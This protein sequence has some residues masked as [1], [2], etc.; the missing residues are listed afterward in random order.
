[1]GYHNAQCLQQ[2]DLG[3]ISPIIDRVRNIL[4]SLTTYID[5]F[6][7]RYAQLIQC[8]RFPIKCG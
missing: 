4:G 3:M 6:K 1:M 5:I 2:N 8:Y 7:H